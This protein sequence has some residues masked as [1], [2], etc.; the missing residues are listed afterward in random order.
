MNR[1]PPLRQI[2]TRKTSRLPGGFETDDE[3]SPT[4]PFYNDTYSDNETTFQT[5]HEAPSRISS[6]VEHANMLADSSDLMNEQEIRNQLMDVDSSFLPGHASESLVGSQDTSAIHSS[7]YNSSIA[8]PTTAFKDGSYHDAG[9][10]SPLQA[11]SLNTSSLETISSSPTAAAAART[12]SRVVSM[13]SM[14]GY[15]TARENDDLQTKG[16]NG[17][18][19]DSIVGDHKEEQPEE[20]FATP[21][22]CSPVPPISIPAIAEMLAADQAKEDIS[23]IRSRPTYLSS[24]FSSSRASYS[25][26]H[27]STSNEYG[28]EFGNSGE[29]PLQAGRNFSTGSGSTPV[30]PGDNT[31]SRSVSLGSLASGVSH[32][33]VEETLKTPDLGTLPEEGS[34]PSSVLTTR[35]ISRE[36]GPQTPRSTLMTPDSITDTILNQHVQNLEISGTVVR[37]FT[38]NFPE[39]PLS[40]GKRD[41]LST[42][43]TGRI[44]NMTLKEQSGMIDKLQKE[45]WQLK[46]KVYYMDQ[47]LNARTDE[48]M[49]SIMTENI[50]LKT[51]KLKLAKDLRDAKRVSRD[52]AA[53]LKDKDERLTAL[54]NASKAGVHSDKQNAAS[55]L[56]SEITILHERIE[57]Y[58][59][60]VE[61]LREDS[62]N[63]DGEIQRL[64]N[65]AKSIGEQRRSGSAEDTSKETQF[66]KDL[67]ETESIQR[68]H[69]EDETRKLQDELWRLRSEGTSAVSGNRS[70]RAS[71]L[72]KRRGQSDDRSVGTTMSRGNNSSLVEDLRQEID[73][74]RRDLGAQTSMLTSRNR[75]KE[76]LYQEIEELKMGSSRAGRGLHSDAYESTTSRLRSHH[77]RTSSRTSSRRVDDIDA[78]AL[79]TQ[80]DELRDAHAKLSMEN[81]DLSTSIEG[82]L[83]EIE[84]KEL[85]LAD[86]EKTKQEYDEFVQQTDV[87]I[88]AMQRERDEALQA[89]E[90]VEIAFQ[91]LREEAQESINALEDELER[92][93]QAMD[94]AE[95]A[96]KQQ[97][98]ESEQLRNQVRMAHEG[99]D[100]I[101]ADVQ[102]K[103]RRINEVEMENQEITREL[104][105]IEESL[106]EA[107]I[108]LEKL[109]VELQSRQN[110]CLFLRDEQDGFAV[111]VGNLEI[112]LKA[113]QTGL[114]SEKG[115]IKELEARIADERRQQEM[116]GSKEKQQVQKIMNDLNR[117]AA[118]AK[119]NAR[120]VRKQLDTRNIELESWKERLRELEA[121]LQE[122]LG[123]SHGKSNYI[124]VSLH[125]RHFLLLTR[126]SSLLW[127]LRE[128]LSLRFLNCLK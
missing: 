47:M 16:N 49:K 124:F 80:I 50:S 104:E 69:A 70:E 110:E 19:G 11:D 17:A 25:S 119:D 120:D 76:K 35:K 59:T 128:S 52:L 108:K 13:A 45:N 41:T 9:I 103:V 126:S 37:N 14:D 117:E 75:E 12:V 33:E 36:V 118:T 40:P 73:D 113:A 43:S 64:A 88:L 111:Q 115:R 6:G 62:A 77:S 51:E 26:N 112:A 65:M 97:N 63:K 22:K 7:L 20:D 2:T 24:R 82:L 38:R 99:L 116:V 21:K 98:E 39:R 31:L 121:G 32:L 100:K 68:Q 4:K 102:A 106:T 127:K 86:H 92:S 10:Y 3:Q 83:D 48:G 55:E 105:T 89:Q 5:S 90:E 94:R 44:K 122:V 46:L 67:V 60:D 71:A 81:Q 107:N 66:W 95:Q 87:E 42:P 79:Q 23:R 29:Y 15:E 72:S 78:E 1:P 58:Q 61:K 96:I 123:E 34:P 54:H 93:A 8:A 57:T 109:S 85:K 56:E 18:N 84:E 101:E 91:D 114:L 30:H 125:V 53:K 27:T 74:L 28:S